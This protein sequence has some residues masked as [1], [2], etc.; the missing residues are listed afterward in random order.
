MAWLRQALGCSSPAQCPVSPSLRC[1]LLLPV[2]PLK[3][4]QG[5]V[6][7]DRVEQNVADSPASKPAVFGRTVSLDQSSRDVASSHHHLTWPWVPVCSSDHFQ[8][9]FI[10][11]LV[12]DLPS[13]WSCKYCSSLQS[14]DVPI[15][16]I[17]LSQPDC[18]APAVVEFREISGLGQLV[19]SRLSEYRYACCVFT[20]LES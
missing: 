6:L 19:P 1:R 20:S 11:A 10:P 3:L 16:S 5:L 2:L 17:R 14:D 15:A 4:R 9:S 18:S 7:M 13:N 12:F 8:R